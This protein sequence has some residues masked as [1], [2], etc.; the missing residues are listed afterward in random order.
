MMGVAFEGSDGGGGDDSAAAAAAVL[1][2][3]RKRRNFLKLKSELKDDIRYTLYHALYQAERRQLE[4]SSAA[5]CSSR[6]L[7]ACPLRNTQDASRHGKRVSSVRRRCG[8]L[9]RWSR[10]LPR[11]RCVQ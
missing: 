10:D 2:V 6:P 9:L 5:V 8:R 3:Q 7:R 4:E 1:V 11:A